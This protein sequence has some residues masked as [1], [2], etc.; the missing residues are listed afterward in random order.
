[1]GIGV[2]GKASRCRLSRSCATINRGALLTEGAAALPGG[3]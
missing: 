2:L 1:M 3:G